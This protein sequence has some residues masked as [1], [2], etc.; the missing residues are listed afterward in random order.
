[1][2]VSP[3]DALK[4]YKVSKPTLYADMKNGKLS[5]KKDDRGK[6]KINIAEL[7]RIYDKKQKK[8][9]PTHTSN[10][11]NQEKLETLPNTID[12]FQLENKYA[13]KVIKQYEDEIEHLRDALKLAQEGHNKATL[14]LGNKSSGNDG[15]GVIQKSLSALETRIDR[16]EQTTRERISEAEKAEQEEQ[17]RTEQALSEKQHYQKSTRLLYAMTGLLIL[18]LIA[19]VILYGQ[20]VIDITPAS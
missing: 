5:Y 8:A 2:F 15:V 17:K 3:T 7:D 19:G 1:M 13:D 4:D 6:R 20:G 14:L 9:E 11:V 16:Q 12:A 10:N 18:I